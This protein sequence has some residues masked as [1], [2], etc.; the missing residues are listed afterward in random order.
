MRRISIVGLVLII[1]LLSHARAGVLTRPYTDS[2]YQTS[3]PFGSMSHWIQPWR[4]TFETVPAHTFLNGIGV[5]FDT[6]DGEKPELIAE[7]LAKHGI[8]QARIEIGWGNLD[9]DTESLHLD[10]RIVGTLKA[11]QKNHIRPLVLLNGNHGAPC[12]LRFFDRVVTVAAAAGDRTVTLDSTDG[13]IIGHSGFNNLTQ[14]CAAEALITQINGKVVTL[15]KPLP[16]AIAAGVRVPMATLKYRPFA[17]PQSSDYRDTIAGWKKY[18]GTVVAAVTTVLGTSAS[19]DKG[20]DLEIWN[21]MSF[22]SNFININ[23]Y[24]SPQLEK[25]S[26]GSIWAGIVQATADA[27]TA[28]PQQYSGIALC[29]GFSNTLPWPASSTEPVRVHA[30][31]HHPYAGRKNFPKDTSNAASIDALGKLDKSGFVPTYTEDFP[32]YFGSFIQTE[33]SV[34]DM[35]SLT[36]DIY[37]VEH[38]RLAR[39]S[40]GKTVPC[41][42]WITEVNYGPDEDGVNDPAEA[43]RLKGKTTARY[44]CFYLGKGT[45]RVYLYDTASGDKGLGIVQDNFLDYTKSH[46]QYPINDFVYTSPALSVTGRIAEQLRIGLDT[47]LVK[48]RSLR[49]MSITDTHDHAQFQGDGTLQHPALFDRDLLALLPLQVNRHR[50]VIP[51]YVI[52]RD[53]KQNLAP[54]AFTVTI[55]GLRGKGATVSTYDPL[56]GVSVPVRQKSGTSDTLTATVRATD[57]PRLLEVT[58]KD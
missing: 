10:D 35:S 53:V 3:V 21:E 25:F 42:M 23:N 4:S 27:A 40:G 30:L 57:S 39:V 52:T 29:D 48:T 11:C 26:E 51:F 2:A 5:V 32:E 50:F 18:A 34:R 43:L 49:V 55:Q 12:P 54:E 41:P 7:M 22:G 6:G 17:D 31:S 19:S 28:T 16:K 37:G 14:Y 33:T 9:Y 47:A 45:E 1:S 8:R 46:N 58:E 36:T 56:S 15:S 20:F 44:Y 38:G 13:L 24:Y